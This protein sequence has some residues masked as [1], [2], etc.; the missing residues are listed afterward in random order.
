MSPIETRPDP[1]TTCARAS[2][3]PRSRT[4]PLAP[5][6]QLSTVYRV[7][8]LDQIDAIYGGEVPGYT[9][10]RDGHPNASQLEAKVAELEGAEAALVCASGMAAESS[11]LLASLSQGD[12]VALSDGLYGKTVALVGRELARFG[13]GHRMFDPTRPETL[14]PAMTPRTRVVFAETIS[15]PLV[16]V[17]DIEGLAEVAHASGAILVIDHSLAPLL[18]RPLGLGA[19]AVTHSLTKLIGGHS[20]LLLGLLAGG[21]ELIGRAAVVASA[22]GLNGN[23][24]ESWLALRGVATLKLRSDR[25]CAN[26]LDLAGRLEGHKKVIAVHY[27]GLPEHP[28]HHRAARLLRG[29]FGTIVTIDVGGRAQADA[30]IKA[31]SHVP[32]APSFGDVSTTL[33]HPATTSHRGQSPEQWAQQ[34]ISPGLIR[35]S[36]GL[37]DPGDLWNDVARALD[38]I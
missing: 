9:Y 30:F 6:L 29:G 36:I 24:F 31:L 23:P 32:F 17:A 18:C 27:P 3:A 22:F 16:R 20:D 19:D 12:D 5:P 8:G 11:V 35:L 26:A 13:I 7:D 2:D 1:S 10:S 4:E 14:R 28:D 33:S 37:E 15:N 21:R 25:A 34:G 38:R